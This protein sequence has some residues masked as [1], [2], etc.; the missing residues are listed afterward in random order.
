MKIN[1]QGFKCDICKNDYFEEIDLNTRYSLDMNTKNIYNK[2]FLCN[3]EDI[4]A[5]CAREV[6]DIIHKIEMK[7][8]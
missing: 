2:C 3:Y 8:V 7:N 6:Y 5:K 1:I 4:C